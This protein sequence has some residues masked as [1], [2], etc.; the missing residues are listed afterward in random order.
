MEGGGTEGGRRERERRGR[1][2]K[3][4]MLTLVTAAHINFTAVT[5]GVSQAVCL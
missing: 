5:L 4:E 3:E 2:E 1:P